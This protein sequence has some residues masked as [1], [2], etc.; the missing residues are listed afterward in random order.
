MPVPMQYVKVGIVGDA[1]QG[2]SGGVAALCFSPDGE[3]LVSAGLD[4]KV[5]IWRMSDG[6]LL[7]TFQGVSPVLSLTWTTSATLLCGGG[8][9][10]IVAIHPTEVS[11]YF[12]ISARF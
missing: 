7:H 9:G 12:H 5:C 6:C 11:V 1:T 2:H 4:S 8:D 10:S 3:Q